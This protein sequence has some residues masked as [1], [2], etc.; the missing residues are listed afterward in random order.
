MGGLRPHP[1]TGEDMGL[2]AALVAADLPTDDLA[3]AG[4][5]FFRFDE[6]G[7]VVGYGG[8]ECHERHALVRSVVVLPEHRGRGI[9]RAITDALIGAAY[10][11]GARDAFLLTTSSAAFFE[12]LGFA[13]IARTDAP[14]AILAT[15]QAAAICASAALLSRSIDHG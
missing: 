3:E 14:A 6:A 7:Q 9:G 15:R 13:T 1:V 12:R 11:A 4:R 5:R 2:R 8:F 10:R